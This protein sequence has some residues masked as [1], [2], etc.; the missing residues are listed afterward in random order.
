MVQNKYT[1]LATI[2]TK[3]K[4]RIKIKQYITILNK[5]DRQ[6]IFTGKKSRKSTS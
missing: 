1:L 4:L 2:L 3:R 6:K 5:N